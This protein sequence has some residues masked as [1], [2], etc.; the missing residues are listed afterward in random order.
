MYQACLNIVLIRLF[1]LF[2]LTIII[3]GIHCPK[4]RG[5]YMFYIKKIAALFCLGIILLAISACTTNKQ[6]QFGTVIIINGPSAVGK[7]SIIKAFQAKQ[8]KPWLG[9]G[10]DNFFIGVLPPKFYLE[11]KPENHSVM[12]GIATEDAHGKLFTLHVGPEGYKVIRGMHQAIAAYARTGN[13]VIV[14]YIMYEPTWHAD[15]QAALAGLKVV[16]IGV[17]ASLKSLEQRE[18]KRGTSPEGHAR[19]LYESVH[20]GWN[21]DLKINTDDITA[22]QAAHH[23][24]QHIEK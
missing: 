12:H 16:T 1:L 20:R 7:S 4:A 18:K 21:Y 3:V 13:N 6:D 8:S 22:D 24:I 10:I 5:L 9:I 11:D 14:D 15:L 19:S 23:I 17:M 2:N